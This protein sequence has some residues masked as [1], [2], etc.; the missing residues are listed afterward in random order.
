[1]YANFLNDINYGKSEKNFLRRELKLKRYNQKGTE[2]SKKTYSRPNKN[3]T[4][5]YSAGK[6]WQER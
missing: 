2:G 3:D 1:M 6:E 4:H 5:L